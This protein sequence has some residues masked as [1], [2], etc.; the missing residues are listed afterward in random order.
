MSRSRSFSIY[1]LKH[2]FTPDNILKEGHGLRSVEADNLPDNAQMYVAQSPTRPPWWKDYWGVQRNLSQGLTGAIVFLNFEN[3]WVALTFGH[4]FHFLKDEGYEYD[5]G[6]RTTLN[7]LDPEKI[8]SMDI[9]QPETAKRQRIQTP[10][11]SNLN[12][13]D[14]RHDESIIKKLTGAVK[15]EY[16]GLFKNATGGSNLRISTRRTAEEIINLC[17]SLVDIYNRSDYL[18]NFPG[19]QNIVPVKDPEKLLILNDQLLNAFQEAPRELVLAIPEIIDYSEPFKVKFSGA[20]RSREYDDVYI[21]AYREY[22]QSSEVEVTDVELFNKHKLVIITEDGQEKNNFRIFKSFLFDCD[23]DNEHYHLCEGEWYKIE[24]DYIQKLSNSINPRVMNYA[25]LRDC[26]VKSEAEYNMSIRGENVL[27]LDRKNIAPNGQTQVE[28]CD[29]LTIE[30][31]KIRLIHV[32]IS[33][34]SSALSHLFN[35]GLNS[36]ELL[37][38]EEISREKL[39]NLSDENVEIK[40]MIERN[41]LKMDVVY[42]IITN[43]A[44]ENIDN[45]AKNLPLFSRISL[46]RILY[47]FKVMGV[48]CWVCFIKDRANRRN[49][50]GEDVD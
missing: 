35:Q 42:G 13:F 40:R 44:G 9:L 36:A 49:A 27:C 8:K 10:T 12:Y 14:I 20:G 1:L 5:F 39:K 23:V 43:K 38:V 29:I 21:G 34:R 47:Q 45:Q 11:A 33:T 19:I 15:Q 31:D 28:P 48:D 46:A 50:E 4:T 7:S 22:L 6:L 3:R 24:S 17:Q 26:T 18:Q 37:R 32:K 2:E 25:L 16:L 30:D 41:P